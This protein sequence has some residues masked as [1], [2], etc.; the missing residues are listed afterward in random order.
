M[1]GLRYVLGLQANNAHESPSLSEGNDYV[2]KDKEG[3]RQ[4]ECFV[5]S[6]NISLLFGLKKKRT[7][8]QEFMQQMKK[9]KKG[10]KLLSS[11]TI[12]IYVNLC[13]RYV[14][15]FHFLYVKVFPLFFCLA[16]IIISYIGI[17]DGFLSLFI[18]SCLPLHFLFIV[19][20][21]DL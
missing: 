9:E 18:F 21:L 16:I 19:F 5:S 15:Y 1:F 3:D 2:S 6:A 7:S 13:A 20:I 17:C 4:W 8:P 11:S 14:I 10:S 12:I